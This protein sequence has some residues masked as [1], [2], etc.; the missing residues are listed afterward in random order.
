MRTEQ[1]R[2]TPSFSQFDP[3]PIPWQSDFVTDVFNTFDYSLGAHEIL[4]SGSVGSGK[5][6]PA[7]HVALRHLFTYAQSRC[8]LARRAMP[9][10]RDTIYTK[11]VEH[12]EGTC[13]PDGTLFREGRDYFLSRHNCQMSFAN[14]S[15]IIARSWADKL[16]SKVGSIE[17]SI[18]ILEEAS[19]N[20]GDD[21]MAFKYL[22]MRVGR[23]PH[24]PQQFII[25]PT[26]PEGPGHFLYEYFQIGQRQSGQT[27]G[28]NPTRHVYFSLT[29]Q[30]PFLPS[31]YVSQ[32]KEDMDPKLAQRMLYGQWVEITSDVVYHCYS[33]ANNFRNESYVVDETLPIY[34]AWD[35]NIAIGKPLSLCLAQKKMEKGA[36]VF[37]FFNEVIIEGASTE[38]A[39]QE[40]ADRGL[41]DFNTEY[42]VQGD[43]TGGSRATKSKSSDYDIIRKFLSNY[44]SRHGALQFTM[45]VG[46]SNP[47][48]RSRHNL[49][50]A[51]CKNEAGRS[52]LFVYKDA[53]ILNKG[54]KLTALRK[55]GSYI[56]DDT[57]D[58]QHV[59]T[60]LGYC[61]S[62][63][64][65]HLNQ[66]RGMSLKQI[67]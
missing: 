10:L 58:Y 3:T 33:E 62:R 48:V 45:D 50:N 16:Y 15:S 18:A 1:L 25:Y 2:S 24:V 38:E 57:K 28:L 14:G 51:Y 35:F 64:I 63:C 5:S 21:E 56:E 44:R 9:D 20:D 37:H 19:E 41:L 17:A 60:A 49:V 59:T 6:L 40:L 31:W 34:L 36:V 23:L 29:E 66:G 27:E 42:I 53:P 52:R 32:L 39:C 61:V 54:M 55:G 4:L 11:V 43:A 46:A 12:L 7:A 26:N 47:P 13:K 30:N 8:V 67:R 65:K 22:R